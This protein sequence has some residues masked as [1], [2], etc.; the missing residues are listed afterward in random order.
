MTHSK[1]PSL[2]YSTTGNRHSPPA[3]CLLEGGKLE[4]E[5]EGDKGP[6]TFVQGWENTVFSQAEKEANSKRRPSAMAARTHMHTHFLRLH[7]NNEVWGAWLLH[8]ALTS[9]I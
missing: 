4:G 2:I 6:G 7:E 3:W 5:E 8:E 9:Y 1:L